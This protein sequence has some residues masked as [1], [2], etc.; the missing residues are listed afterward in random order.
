MRSRHLS[1]STLAISLAMTLA[2]FA[3]TASADRLPWYSQSPTATGSGGAAATEH[4]LATQAAITILNAG[5]NAVDA[6]VAAS[7]VQGV[8]RPFSGGIGGG[9][10]MQIYLADDDRVLVL[11]HRSS[12]PASFD[13]ET[14]ID[15]VSGGEYDEAV[16][17]NSG[18][19]V[20]VPGVVKAWE[21][22]VTLYGSGSVTLAQILQPA[23]DVAE[24]GFYADANYIREVTENQQRLCAFTS[25]IAIYLNSDCSV[26]AVGTLVTN[27]D[28]ADMYQLIA[29]SGSSAFYS[30]AV[31]S[32]IVS[33]V[34]S[35]PVRTTGTPIPFYVQPGNM[36]TSDLSSYSVPEYAALHVNYRGYDVYGPPPSS[37]GGTTI[38]EM[39]NVLEGYPMASLPREQALHYYLE[40]SRR[41]FADRSAYLGDPLTY[42]NPMPVAGLLSENYAEHVRQ[43]IQDR[44][45]Q[46]FVAASDPWPFDANPLLK[47]RPLP[48]DGAGAVTFDFTGLANGASWD[49]GGQFVSETR[50]ASESIEVLDQSGDMQITSAQF[51]YVRAASQMDAAPDTEL[52]VRFKPDSLTGDR[53]LRFWLRADGWNATT[54]P[55][56]GYAVEISSSSDTVRIIRTRNGNA[57][58][59]LASFTHARSLDWQWLRF[60]VEGDQLSVRF[61]DEGDNE[62]R[63]TWTHT[64]TDTSVTAPGGF[65][66]ALIE[67]G[68][69][70][71][72]GGGFRVDDMFVTDLKPVAFSS[73]F[74][75]SNG[76][77]WDSTGQFTTQFGTGNSNPGVGASINV[78]SNAGRIYLDK[79]QYAYARATADMAPLTNSELLVRFRMNDLTDD[80][81]LRF[82]L[83]ADSWNSLGS[84]HNG[85]GIEIQSDVDQ[86]RMFRVRQSNG[87]FAL[88][89]LAHTRTT[90]WQ[91]LRFRVEGATMKVRIWADGSPEPLT[92]LG[93]LSNADVTAPGKLLIGALENTGGT[94]VTGGSFD[95]DDLT[96]YD[97]DVM[98]SGGGGGDDGSSTIHLTTADSD[99]NIVAYTHTLN[100]IG[101]NGAVVP[102]YG[103]ILNN[104]LNTRVPSKSAVGHP[105]GPRPGMR[106]LSSMS[107]TMVFQNGNPVLAIGSP[108]GETII[109]TVLQVLLNRL[110]FGM[111]LPVAVES[112]RATQRNTS[113]FGHT[114]V[115]PGFALIPEY[116]DLLDRGQLFDI[117]GLTYGTGAVNAVEFL[118]NNKVRA[119]SEAWRRGGGSAMV[120]T[121][122]P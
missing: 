120:Q 42:A 29:T 36:L 96:V 46:R 48:A 16:R 24:D 8:V 34:N 111:S 56:N 110:D 6:A 113:A 84:P 71:T 13:E 74:T 9:G 38:G 117:S 2:S 39:L 53:R 85:Y 12:A 49:S 89:T 44:G 83:R 62:P 72:S 25:T 115:E 114:L 103:F 107:P 122:D 43:H 97:L 91:W 27:Q 75:A 5:G 58:F 78:Q 118:P 60:R 28:L 57:V 40:T 100:S 30:G 82:W 59:A 121:P 17:N 94:G 51:S 80:R 19:A 37:S 104:E 69:T 79:T 61:W 93:E 73:N 10:Y 95:I 67:L 105:N 54:S 7:A 109:T 22:A 45:T 26:P 102:G 98:E 108:G 77:T 33:T 68:N 119:V 21:K 66:T 35:P 101:G 47:A 86:V 18:A 41:A 4:P 31:A 116:D 1:R 64:M 20:G 92:W 3:S 32:A 81:S 76:A 112:P 11:D 14:F 55:F 65:L 87:A 15:P 70:S 50:S 106:P 88:R 99:G 23:I 63:H 90:A 52:L